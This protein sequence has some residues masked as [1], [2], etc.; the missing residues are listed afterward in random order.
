M[1]LVHR[2]LAALYKIVAWRFGADLHLYHRWL[3]L[4]LLQ[5]EG[6]E[7]PKIWTK[8][9]CV[10]FVIRETQEIKKQAVL[11]Q[12]WYLHNQHF[13]H[14]KK[15]SKWLSSTTIRTTTITRHC[16]SW[17]ELCHSLCS[18]FHHLESR[19]HSMYA[20]LISVNCGL[21]LQPCLRI[22]NT[23]HFLNASCSPH[24]HYHILVGKVGYCN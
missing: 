3:L 10:G 20:L 17:K 21:D 7:C 16:G 5:Y 19:S 24:C 22:P 13:R 6:E 1:E 23:S 2:N 18:L 15:K 9:I 12:I 11:A 14:C 8:Q 4:W